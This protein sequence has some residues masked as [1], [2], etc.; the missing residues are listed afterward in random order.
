MISLTNHDSSEGEQWGEADLG[1]RHWSPWFQPIYT[2]ATKAT[3]VLAPGYKLL[4]LF[5]HRTSSF[6]H[7]PNLVDLAN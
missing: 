7:Q 3:K 2:K 5:T 1:R 6:F 4:A